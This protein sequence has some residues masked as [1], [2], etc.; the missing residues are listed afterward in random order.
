MFTPGLLDLVIVGD[1]KYGNSIAFIDCNPSFS[2][3]TEISLLAATHVIVPCSGD[4]SSARAIDN[5]GALVYGWG[6]PQELKS[7]SF[8][9]RV[10]R[11]GMNLAVGLLGLVE[12]IHPVRSQGEQGVPGHV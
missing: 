1:K 12:S 4:G 7:A 8:S 3:Y 10:R 6:L 9:E 2:A 5:L 11:F